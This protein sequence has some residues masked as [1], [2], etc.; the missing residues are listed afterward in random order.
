MRHFTVHQAL[1][2]ASMHPGEQPVCTW[3]GVTAKASSFPGHAL[4]HVDGFL[5]VVLRPT[6]PL[7]TSWIAA[8]GSVSRRPHGTTQLPVTHEKH[9]TRPLTFH[10][11]QHTVE[12]RRGRVCGTV[13]NMDVF[14]EPPWTGSRRVPHTRTRRPS[15]GHAKAPSYSRRSIASRAAPGDG[16]RCSIPTA[17]K[18]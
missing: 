7:R 13:E 12:G 18:A 8:A 3:P 11:H 9:R 1:P 15:S 17:T 4:S 10:G 5:A 16:P 14:Y 6:L 2:G